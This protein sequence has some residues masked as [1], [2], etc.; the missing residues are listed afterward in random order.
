MRLT[1]YVSRYVLENDLADG[2]IEQLSLRAKLLTQFAGGELTLGG[3]SDE[4]LNRW[5]VARQEQGLSPDT[6]A[7]DRVKA[8]TLWRSAAQA[9]LCQP[10]GKIRRIKR[11]QKIPRA[12]TLDDVRQLLAAADKLQGTIQL[13]IEGKWWDSGVSRRLYW[14]AWIRAAYDS[15]LRRSDLLA[16]ERNWIRPTDSGGAVSLVQHKTGKVI[17]KRFRDTTMRAIDDLCAGRKTGPIWCGY[18]SRRVWCQAFKRLC[19]RAGV[20]G[21]G[22]WLRRSSA[23]YVAREHGRDE[24]KRH[25]GHKSDGVVDASYLDPLIAFD[26]PPLPPPLPS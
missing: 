26:E 8:L 23:S 21:S 7:A 24:A 18:P 6:V 20:D 22:K 2:S 17:V 19:K 16:I 25:L 3:L 12:F 5:L 14:L 1:D 11:P 10:P 4:L 13:K 9:G 15:A